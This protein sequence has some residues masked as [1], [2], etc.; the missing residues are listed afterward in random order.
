MLTSL[1]GAKAGNAVGAGGGPQSRGRGTPHLPRRDL[2]PAWLS[3]LAPK[4]PP[5]QRMGLWSSSWAPGIAEG[6]PK[7]TSRM[8]QDSSPRAQAEREGR[9]G[10]RQQ[11]S[12]DAWAG[13]CPPTGPSLRAPG[14]VVSGAGT[15]GTRGHR[16]VPRGSWYQ[17]AYP[18]TPVPVVPHTGPLFD[19]P[20][21][22]ILRSVPPPACVPR[23]GPR[24][25]RHSLSLPAR[26]TARSPV[27]SRFSVIEGKVLPPPPRTCS[28]PEPAHASSYYL[29]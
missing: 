18:T 12:S 25:G 1:F 4:P 28:S 21:S 20:G 14:A 19:F 13:A 2:K 10:G 17:P 15:A 29:C 7:G 8:A 27:A 16:D 3:S 22:H 26:H 9:P 5:R 24:P 11:G 23:Q 6:S